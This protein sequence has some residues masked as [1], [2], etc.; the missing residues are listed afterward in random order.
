[1]ETKTLFILVASIILSVWAIARGG[2]KMAVTV[3]VLW[4]LGLLVYYFGSDNTIGWVLR[5]DYEVIPSTGIQ[6]PPCIIFP[7]IVVL[8]LGRWWCYIVGG[9][10]ALWFL[11]LVIKFSWNFVA[12]HFGVNSLVSWVLVGAVIFALF[13]FLRGLWVRA[14]A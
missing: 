1:M 12:D 14:R 5:R 7:F 3:G 8:L 2:S 6:I 13:I 11:G 10:L 9:V 4:V